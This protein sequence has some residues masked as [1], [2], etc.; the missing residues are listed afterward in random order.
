MY[1]VA[2]KMEMKNASILYSTVERA[3]AKVKAEKEQVPE[4]VRNCMTCGKKFFSWGPGNRLCDEH[5][6]AST[7]M[8][9]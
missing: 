1:H 7:G 4:N 6:R 5:R 3:V 9:L 8:D 2:R